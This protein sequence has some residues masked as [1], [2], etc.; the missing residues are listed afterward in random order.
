MPDQ[1]AQNAQPRDVLIK[2]PCAG[3]T[4]TQLD[5]PKDAILLTASCKRRLHDQQWSFCATRYGQRRKV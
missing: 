3:T 5:N 2:L 1:S 4:R